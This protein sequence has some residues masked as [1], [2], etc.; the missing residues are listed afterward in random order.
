MKLKGKIVLSSVLICIVSILSIA[1]I[2]Y[3]IS[4]KKLET[5]I[6]TRAQLETVSMAKD[7]NTWIALQKIHWKKS[8]KA[9]YI[10][11]IMNMTLSISIL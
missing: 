4:I 6:N 5:E 9:L 1:L 11:T 8:Y 2:N 7:A 10:M 3:V